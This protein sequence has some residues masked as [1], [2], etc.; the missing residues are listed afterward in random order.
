M[1]KKSLWALG[2]VLISLLVACGD[3]G[4]DSDS[5]LSAAPQEQTESNVRLAA[6]TYWCTGEPSQNLQ[7]ARTNFAN[8]CAE[9]WN[10]A[11]HVC[12]YKSDGFHCNGQVSRNPDNLGSEVE[13]GGPDPECYGFSRTDINASKRDFAQRCNRPYND[14]EGHQCFWRTTGWL[15]GGKIP[16]RLSETEDD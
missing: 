2:A 1:N 8:R 16:R 4:V 13:L 12:D 10:P 5:T 11:R 7:Q 9:A 15:C 6:T 3:S 14:Q